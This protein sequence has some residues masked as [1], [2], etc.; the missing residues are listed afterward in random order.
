[1]DLAKLYSDPSFPGSYSGLER[2]YQAVKERFPKVTRLE[3]RE[4]LKSQDAYTLHKTI[5]KPRKYRRTLVFAPRDLWQ[6]DL[7]DMQKYA[8]ENRGYRYMCVIIDCFSKF[9][10]I[11][12]LKN[13]RG[14][15]TVKALALLLMNERPSRIQADQ[16]SEFFNKDV[17][18]MLEA[19]GPKLYHTFSDKKAAIVE[20]VQRTIRQRLGR[21]F[22]RENN[23]NWI[24][25]IQNLVDSYNNTWHRTI[26]MKPANVR[27]EHIA[28]IFA[29]LFP[30]E[31]IKKAKFKV[32][33]R[34]RITAKRTFLQK[35]YISGWTKEIFVI[36]T[37]QKTKPITYILEDESKETISGGF[38]AEELQHVS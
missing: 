7:L 15:E 29:R 25:H 2:F 28:N 35:E 6:I 27:S 12:P 37:V 34:V 16:G 38:Y 3:V 14:K 30:D 1:M 31:V 10:W 36:N 22:T 23:H 32:G 24:D 21:L 26:Q 19:F 20:R 9:M 18:K 5:R 4:F 13:K 8:R 17:A 33:D 11:K